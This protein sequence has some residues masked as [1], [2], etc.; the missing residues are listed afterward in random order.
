[1]TTRSQTAREL[2]AL[3]EEM[4]TSKRQRRSRADRG[5]GRAE[6]AQADAAA[7]ETA[8][9][10]ADDG[11][12]LDMVKEFIDEAEHNIAEHPA[13]SVIGALLVGILIGR[14][15]GGR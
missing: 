5:I 3:H 14:L 6:E 7:K 1:M 4:S 11:D 9:A 2:S 10:A 8:A 15:L 13:T 12:F